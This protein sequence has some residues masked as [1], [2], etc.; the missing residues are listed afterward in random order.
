MTTVAHKP[1]GM[2]QTQDYKSYKNDY[3]DADT[4]TCRHKECVLKRTSD[5]ERMDGGIR[6][7]M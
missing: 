2:Q 4:T 3:K 1:K 6:L 5:S 7:F